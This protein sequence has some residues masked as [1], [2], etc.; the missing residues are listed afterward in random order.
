MRR[1]VFDCLN[2]SGVEKK[3]VRKLDLFTIPVYV[4]IYFFSFLDRSNIGNSKAAGMATDLKLKISEFNVI[5]T[6]LADGDRI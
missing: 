5:M 3:L 1:G 6:L 2:R 4:I